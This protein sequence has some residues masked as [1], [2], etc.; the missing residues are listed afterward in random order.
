MS[1]PWELP[2]LDFMVKDYTAIMGE[3]YKGHI[4]TPAN[5][6]SGTEFIANLKAKPAGERQEYVVQLLKEGHI[7]DFLREPLKVTKSVNGHTITY[8][9]MP[10]V[11]AIGTNDD[12]VPVPMSAEMVREVALA[13][14]MVPP[15]A[16]M[17]EQ[18]RED[19]IDV[20]FRQA[21]LI[22]DPKTPKH[23][24]ITLNPYR[25]A[26]D[27]ETYFQ[28]WK[29]VEQDFSNAAYQ[30]L[31]G[32]PAGPGDALIRH[33]DDMRREEPLPHPRRQGQ[34]VNSPPSR[35]TSSG[36]RVTVKAANATSRW[37][38]RLGPMIAAVI[39]G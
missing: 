24:G 2:L 26:A 8:Y 37:A 1:P 22:D 39:C 18:I 13:Y 5:P 20:T 30:D 21:P 4:E 32:A 28:H 36:D 38:G 14:E 10:N 16:K 6:I 35:A 25:S 9:T 11:L 27:A 23:D 7:P 33:S 15:T 17:V 19:S 34:K 31:T 12:Y 29:K 3:V